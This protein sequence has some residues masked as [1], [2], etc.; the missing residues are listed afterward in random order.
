MISAEERQILLDL[1]EFSQDIKSHLT[2][3]GELAA[4]KGK[5][6]TRAVQQ[7]SQIAL[8]P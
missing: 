1:S 7:P 2:L 3:I 4:R 6:D 8:E 5:A